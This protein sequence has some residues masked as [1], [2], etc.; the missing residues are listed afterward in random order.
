MKGP[1]KRP[2]AIRYSVR[3]IGVGTVESA[4]LKSE[5]LGLYKHLRRTTEGTFFV[6]AYAV[7]THHSG[8]RLVYAARRGKE[9]DVTEFFE[10]A[11]Q[12]AEDVPAPTS[13]YYGRG[14]DA[15]E[16]ETP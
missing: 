4:L 14:I 8:K 5:A 1:R 16:K 10:K 15:I 6:I 12:R 7:P 2:P 11:Y 3:Q 13:G 9:R